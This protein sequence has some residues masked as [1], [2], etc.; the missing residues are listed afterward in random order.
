MSGYF[1][2]KLYEAVQALIS[3]GEIDQRLTFAAAYLAH[4]QERDVP[5]KYLVAF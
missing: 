1:K 4:L 3:E 2:Q 5:P